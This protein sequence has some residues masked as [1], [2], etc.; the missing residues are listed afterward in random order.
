LFGVNFLVVRIWFI[1]LG[2]AAACSRMH[3]CGV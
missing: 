1:C 3:C 2:F